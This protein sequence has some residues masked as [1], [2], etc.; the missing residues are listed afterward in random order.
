MNELKY[1]FIKSNNSHWMNDFFFLIFVFPWYILK[2]CYKK[3]DGEGGGRVQYL[4]S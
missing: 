3:K 4:H 2:S 1:C